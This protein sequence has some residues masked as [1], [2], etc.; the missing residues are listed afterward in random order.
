MRAA[1]AGN[2]EVKTSM[3]VTSTA[4]A[5][6]SMAVTS[7]AVTSMAVGST[8]CCHVESRPCPML[9]VH[10]TAQHHVPGTA[11]PHPQ[12]YQPPTTTRPPSPGDIYRSAGFQPGWECWFPARKIV[13]FSG[14]NPAPKS[15]W[16]PA[17]E[18]E[19]Q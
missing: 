5:V 4:M 8:S 7:M 16:N 17:L 3:A 9:T 11:L 15:G 6:T 18:I 12:T 1:A 14:W 19:I 13:K 2:R 10:E